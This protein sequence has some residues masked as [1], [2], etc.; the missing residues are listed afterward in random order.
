M[1]ENE[2]K[3][4][5]ARAIQLFMPGIPQIWY[6]DI[7]AGANDYGLGLANSVSEMRD[8]IFNERMVE[9]S[10]EGKRN[11]DLR[12]TRRFHLL[13]GPLQGLQVTLRQSSYKNQLEAIVNPVTGERYRDQLDMNNRDTVSK[14]FAYSFVAPGGTTGFNVP[15][16]STTDLHMVKSSRNR[17]AGYRQTKFPST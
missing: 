15:E 3:L 12:R 5:L 7:F 16:T 8:L 1:G 4:A 6:L 14:Y 2:Q 13:S 11:D 9:L 17:I 10:F